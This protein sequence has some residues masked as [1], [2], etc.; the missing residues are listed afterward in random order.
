MLK[1]K[2][3]CKQKGIPLSALAKSLGISQGAL[4][5]NIAGR[6]GLDRLIDIAKLLDVNVKDLF[7]GEEIIGFIKSYSKLYEINSI[8]DLELVLSETKKA[9]S[10][11]GKP[12]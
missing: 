5:Q 4:S 3:I 10:E 11:K 8:E 1:I 7:E 12:E 6:V 9:K 2:E